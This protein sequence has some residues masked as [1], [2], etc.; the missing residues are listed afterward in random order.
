MGQKVNPIGLRLGITR[1]SDSRWYVEPKQFA[2]LL[3]EDLTLRKKIKTKYFHAGIAKI[4]F[5]RAGNRCKVTITTARPGIIIGPKGSEIEALRKSLQEETGK[6]VLINIEEA[7][8]S[9]LNAQLVAENIASQLERRIGFRRAMKKTLQATMD[10]G[11]QGIRVA[12]HGRLAGA[13]MARY[14]WYRRGRVP[15]HTLRADIDYGLAEALTKVGIVGVKVWI[16]KG[17]VFEKKKVR[18]PKGESDRMG[19]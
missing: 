12:C 3:H 13:E 11:A 6:T 14:E 7:K 10:A 5:E 1:Q 2:S 18:G 17:E 15:L 16:F 4:E 19:K 9:E 8:R